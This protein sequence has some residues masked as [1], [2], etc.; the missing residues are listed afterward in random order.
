MKCFKNALETDYISLIDRAFHYGDG[1]FSTARIRNG[2]IELLDLHLAR[3]ALAC[4][5][6]FLK[7][8]VELIEA[9]LKQINAQE[10]ANGI[11]KIVISRG[12]GQRGYSL[13]DHDAD[14]WVYY[15]PKQTNDFQPEFIQAGILAQRMGFSMP[16]IVGLK[17]LNRLE[18]V[19]LKKEADEKGWAEAIACDLQGNIVEGVSSNCFIR[20]KNRWITPELRY[21]GVH[22]IMRAEILRRMQQY[23]IECEQSSIHID[24]I[25][26]IQSLFFCNALNPM[27]IVTQL[28]QQSLDSQV[29]VDLFNSLHLNQMS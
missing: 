24:E 27:K 12:N 14:L 3:L 28:D 15:Y 7:F 11:L 10:L 9:S 25:E 16:N 13:P 2:R 23:N 6:L 1:C 29:C 22:G 21:N 8:D 17:T 19:L 4:E 5:K 18:Q 26:N 20:I